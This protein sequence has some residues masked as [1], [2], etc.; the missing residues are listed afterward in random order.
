MKKTLGILVLVLCLLLTAGA[1]AEVN[2]RLVLVDQPDG[3]VLLEPNGF[4]AELAEDFSAGATGS[5]ENVIFTT[6]TLNI[7]VDNTDWNKLVT[8]GGLGDSNLRV[9]WSLTPPGEEYQKAYFWDEYTVPYWNVSWDYNDDFDYQFAEELEGSRQLNYGMGFATYLRQDERVTFTTEPSFQYIMVRWYKS[10]TEYVTDIIKLV[11]VPSS[12]MKQVTPSY[13]EKIEADTGDMILS[14]K[15]VEN[16]EIKYRVSEGLTTLNTKIKAPADAVSCTYQD[17]TTMV[18]G[19]WISLSTPADKTGTN[20]YVLNWTKQD[21]STLTQALVITVSVKGSKPTVA[22][23][24]K[25][26]KLYAFEALADGTTMDFRLNAL[27]DSLMTVEK[28]KDNVTGWMNIKLKN[29][30]G[31]PT[32][33]WTDLEKT[34]YEIEL[35]VP[36]G[37]VKVVALQLP[38]NIFEPI[39]DDIYNQFMARTDEPDNYGAVSVA[40]QSRYVMEG[41]ILKNMTPGDKRIAVYAPYITADEDRGEVWVFYFYDEEGARSDQGLYAIVTVSE[42]GT[43]HTT[44]VILEADL[45]DGAVEYPLL[46]SSNYEGWQLQT[47]YNIQSGNQ[48]VQMDLTLLDE[49]G[50]V[51]KLEEQNSNVFYLPY[52]EGMSYESGAT[53]TLRHYLDDEY[54]TYE[55]LTVTATEHG[56]RFETDSLSPFVLLWDTPVE[57]SPIPDTTVAPTVPQTGDNTPLALYAALLAI[58]LAAAVALLRRKAVR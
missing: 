23:P 18:E 58:S 34:A 32:V 43:L 52:P 42:L 3:L 11:C 19:G 10:E 13:V 1:M 38:Q 45:P 37:A 28:N 36:E 5:T 57:E 40:G 30:A 55:L 25:D 22:A 8:D 7:D 2:N 49:E 50:E 41:G 26:E 17:T 4:T 46:V 21:G 54:T 31:I 39:D 51:A 6:V 47:E 53:W 27:A 44:D 24:E 29:T 9:R 15:K 16:Y 56:L 48:A 35:P 33:A 20:H 14:A 12:G